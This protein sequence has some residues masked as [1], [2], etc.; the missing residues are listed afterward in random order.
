[1][2][3]KAL[4]CKW[5]YDLKTKGGKFDKRKARLVVVGTSQRPG[6][7]YNLTFAPVARLETVRLLL[8]EAFLK[9]ELIDVM[10]VK[11]AY[12]NGVLDKEVYIKQPKG[13]MKPGTEHLVCR[14]IKGLYGLKQAGRI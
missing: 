13:F 11:N 6:L 14:L 7:D 12:L 8:V 10:D 4:H 2:G 9:G 5:V 3:R 1:M